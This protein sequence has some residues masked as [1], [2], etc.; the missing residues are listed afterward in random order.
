MPPLT[1]WFI[2]TAMISLAFAFL[3]RAAMAILPLWGMH[4]IVPALAPV[5]LH[6]FMWGWVTQMIFGVV[7][8]M[9]PKLNRK[10]PRGH[11]GLWLVTF[12]TFNI[13]LIFR[14]MGEPLHLLRPEALWAWLTMA[15]AVLQWLA[16][17]A[18]VAN[19]WGRVK[20]R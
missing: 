3:A 9:F 10:S 7:Y 18:F 19:T 4:D 2:K 13:G 5:F 6:L 20:E 17:M 12:W 1:R 14:V 16:G 11:E 15:A 8:W